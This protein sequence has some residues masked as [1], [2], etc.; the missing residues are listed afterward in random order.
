M[1]LRLPASDSSSMESLAQPQEEE[2]DTRQS[3]EFVSSVM[4]LKKPQRAEPAEYSY[5]VPAIN[6]VF[7]TSH[8][9]LKI[10]FLIAG[11]R[12]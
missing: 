9:L 1:G 8:Y 3:V 12:K 2:Q 7:C 4:P 5:S 11:I 6:L 10:L